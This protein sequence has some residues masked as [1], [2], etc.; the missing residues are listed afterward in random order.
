MIVEP[1]L[2]GSADLVIGSRIAGVMEKG[3]MPLH[4]RLGNRF[5]VGLLRLLYGVAITDLGS[6]RAI[7]AESLFQLGMEQMTYGWPMEMVIKAAR[8]GLRV[9]SVPIRYRKRLGQ[10]K[11]TGTWRGTI[12][13]TYYLVL[14]PLWY[15][16]GRK[17]S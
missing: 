9:Q 3:A 11:V 16:F 8:R 13:A 17:R 15:F 2:E 6:F 4:G 14:L 12:L 5:I 7:R 1:I 10:S